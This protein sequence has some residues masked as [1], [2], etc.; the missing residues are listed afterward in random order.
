MIFQNDPTATTHLLSG[1]RTTGARLLAHHRCGREHPIRLYG[2]VPRFPVRV[3]QTLGSLA[4]LPHSLSI[5]FS[6][7]RP[8]A[9]R[10]APII[11]SFGTGIPHPRL[12]D[13]QSPA[14]TCPLLASFLQRPPRRIL[15][16]GFEVC[17]RTPPCPVGVAPSRLVRVRRSYFMTFQYFQ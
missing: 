7:H 5:T 13:A 15:T 14:E 16:T 8:G 1:R 12:G 11:S 6:P 10:V 2:G 17:R 4:T 3:S 9:S